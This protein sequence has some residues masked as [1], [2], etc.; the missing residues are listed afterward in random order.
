MH[1]IVEPCFSTYGMRPKLGTSYDFLSD[2]RT[3]QHHFKR[4]CWNDESAMNFHDWLRKVS[5]NNERLIS[6][7]VHPLFCIASWLLNVVENDQFSSCLNMGPAS[8]LKARNGRQ[9]KI[10]VLWFHWT[11]NYGNITYITITVTLHFYY[12]KYSVNLICS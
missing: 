7:V 6:S 3:L 10:T 4:G 11:S 5:F 12:R 9:H 2:A 8:T 1:F